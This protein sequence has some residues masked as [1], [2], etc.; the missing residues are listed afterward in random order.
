MKPRA[1]AAAAA[2]ALTA[3]PGGTLALDPTEAVRKEEPRLRVSSHDPDEV[4]RFYL[5][6]G[7]TGRIILD[8]GETV[9]P[10]GL[11]VS[12][13]VALGE[14]EW[15]KED[16]EAERAAGARMNGGQQGETS[17]DRNLC[18]AIVG[19]AVFLTPRR[20]L[21]P[22]SLFLRTR[23][24]KGSYCEEGDYTFELTT[25][26]ES[27][28]VADAA[29]AAPAQPKPF[30][31]VRFTYAAREARAAAALRAEE[32]RARA[33]RW[34]RCQGDDPPANCPQPQEPAPPPSAPEASSTWQF[35]RCASHP[36]LA[37][38]EA[39]SSGRTLFLRYFGT[40]KPPAFYERRPDGEP[41]LAR[42]TM[43]PEPSHTTVVVAGLPKILLLSDGKRGSCIVHV[44]PDAPGLGHREPMAVA[45]PAGRPPWN[46]RASR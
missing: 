29:G 45:P 1:I 17:C 41:A 12:D 16:Q 28:K 6:V 26:P 5:K 37:P 7:Q 44:G 21:A 38:D 35:A 34:R 22:Q 15:T 43:E 36:D 11:L 8:R 19:S 27:A 42:Y 4:V 40:R 32:M 13:Q 14:E 30:Y 23:W 25:E 46:R 9:L 20:D 31:S 39:W 24:C 18:R 2:L 33:E 3:L 10:G